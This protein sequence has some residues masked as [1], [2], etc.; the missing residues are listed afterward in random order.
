MPIYEYRCDACGHV[1]E[2]WQKISDPPLSRCEACGGPVKKI[3]SLNTFHLKGSGWYVTDYASGSS[4]HDTAQGE[5]KEK[6]SKDEVTRNTKK[7]A[8]TKEK[9]DSQKT[10]I[11]P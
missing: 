3:I 9:T 7:A 2:A 1:M 10:D 5:R 11:T 4:K 8:D 6:S